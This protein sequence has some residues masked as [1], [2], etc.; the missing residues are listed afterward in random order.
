MSH[1]VST[2]ALCRSQRKSLASFDPTRNWKLITPISKTRGL[3]WTGLQR[4]ILFSM[5]LI[6]WMLVVMSTAC[7]LLRMCP[8]WKAVQQASTGRSRSSKKYQISLFLCFYKVSAD[9]KLV[10]YRMLRLHLQRGSQNLPRLHYPKYTKPTHTLHRVGQELSSSVNI[11]D[12]C[13]ECAAC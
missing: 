5:P 10:S 1:T 6:I 7:A 4:S 13:F 11:F 12:D 3:M 8:W 2:H 9:G